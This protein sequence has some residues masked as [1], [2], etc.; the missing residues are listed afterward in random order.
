MSISIGITP[1][2]Q[3]N[4]CGEA[5]ITHPQTARRQSRRQSSRLISASLDQ[6]ASYAIMQQAIAFGKW[7][8]VVLTEP[9]FFFFFENAWC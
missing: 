9:V 3:R 4:L 8:H 6:G 5:R 1:G 2:H 7:K